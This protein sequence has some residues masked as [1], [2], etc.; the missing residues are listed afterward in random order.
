MYYSAS[1][2]VFFVV[3]LDGMFSFLCV[4][5]LGLGS[6]LYKRFLLFPILKLFSSMVMLASW[7][8]LLL[9]RGEEKRW[10]VNLESIA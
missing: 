7:I 9:L 2:L 10:D 3:I 8:V 6:L 4:L 5:G 1:Y